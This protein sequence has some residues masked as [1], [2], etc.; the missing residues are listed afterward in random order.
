MGKRIK[1][2]CSLRE[3]KKK[4]KKSHKIKFPDKIKHS[5]TNWGKKSTNF[6]PGWETEKLKGQAGNVG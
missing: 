5:L 1:L 6:T 4:R 2:E 3:N